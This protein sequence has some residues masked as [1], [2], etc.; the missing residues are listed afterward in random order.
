V[1]LALIGR[2]ASYEFRWRRWALLRDTVAALDVGMPIPHFNSIGDAL[3]GSLRLPAEDLVRE[4]EAIHRALRGRTVDTLMLGPPTAS[5][6]Y[7]GVKLEEPRQLTAR[8]LAQ[9]APP[10][11]IKDLAEYFASMCDSMID[12]CKTPFADNRVEVLEA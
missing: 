7:M 12:V 1:S 8:E 10:G 4:V 2:A 6:L 9:I 11:E 5:V 3:V